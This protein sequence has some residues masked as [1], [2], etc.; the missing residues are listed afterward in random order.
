MRVVTMTG[1]LS[2]AAPS[3]LRPIHLGRGRGKPGDLPIVASQILFQVPSSSI[4]LR[5]VLTKACAPESLGS[6][7]P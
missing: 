2:A 3:A 4:V 6:P 5:K 7:M 1:M